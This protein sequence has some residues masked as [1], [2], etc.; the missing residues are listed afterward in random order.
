VRFPQN[1]GL[2]AAYQAGLNACMRLGADIVVNTDAD[3]QYRGQDIAKLIEPILAQEAD[4]VIGDRQTDTIKHFSLL[5]RLL[6]RWGSRIVR[7]ASGTEVVDAAS[8]FRAINSKAMSYLFV[9][10]KFTYT[11]ETIIQA[12]SIGLNI[13]NV[14][15]RTNP[16]KRKSRL[17]NSIM[18]YLRRN[19]P[20]IFR[21]YTMYWPVQTFGYMGL[22]L[23]IFGLILV[24]RFLFYFIQN[25]NYSGHIQSLQ[26]GVGSIILAF[27]VGLI[28]LLGDLLAS[29][30]RLTEEILSRVKKLEAPA[31]LQNSQFDKNIS[32]RFEDVYKTSA[33]SWRSSGET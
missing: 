20:V 9:H 13:K 16:A 14:K 7:R 3:N 12:G 25:P 10:N 11:L 30:R 27:I 31:V 29:N 21:S 22:A 26:V 6:Q 17:A 8:G 24:V 1:R 5:K 18:D 19:G 2:S 15:I 33:S 23:F 4:M 32:Y 28:A